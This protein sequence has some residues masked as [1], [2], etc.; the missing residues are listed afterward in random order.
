ML[1]GL[2]W[3]D[4]HYAKNLNLNFYDGYDG[5]PKPTL[6]INT[7]TTLCYDYLTGHSPSLD[8]Y[9]TAEYSVEKISSPMA[10]GGRANIAFDMFSKCESR[11][12]AV[13]FF[14]LLLSKMSRRRHWWACFKKEPYAHNNNN[15]KNGKYQNYNN[16]SLRGNLRRPTTVL[17]FSFW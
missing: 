13:L 17:R 8:K 10:R 9:R 16:E 7:T 12:T 11:S 4:A 1:I 6:T 3:G 15:H 5:G 14:F 2:V